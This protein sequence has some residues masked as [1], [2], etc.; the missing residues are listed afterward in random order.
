M[1]KFSLALALALAA[2]IGGG[3]VLAGPARAAPAGGLAPL[4]TAAGDINAVEQA[5]YVYRGRRYCWYINGWRGPGW[6]RC[7]YALRRGLG[8]GGVAGWRGWYY[9]RGRYYHRRRYW[10]HRAWR[11]GRW[12]YR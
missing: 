4:G 9:G 8:W 6:Y 7:G 12:H 1:R 11:G 5:Q 2:A 3:V 10:H